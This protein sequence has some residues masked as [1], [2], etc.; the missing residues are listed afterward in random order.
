MSF[1]DK[2]R[3]GKMLH[4]KE[5]R[6]RYT[7]Y[8]PERPANMPIRDFAAAVTGGDRIIAEI[9]HRSPSHPAFT[10]PAR[11]ATLARLYQRNGAAAQSIVVDQEHFGTSLADVAEV[12]AACDLPVLTK[13]FV[14]DETQITEAWAAGADCVLL[15]VRMLEGQRLTALLAFAHDL[16]LHVLVECHDLTDIEMATAA[17]ARIVGVNNRNLATLRTDLA[18]GAGMLPHLPGGVIRVSESGLYTRDDILTMAEHGADTFLIGHALLRSDDPGRK[19]AELSA[20]E[21]EERTRV[22]VCGITNVE[23]ARMA[24]AAGADILGLILADSP[25]QVDPDQGRAIRQA[26]PR[27]RL[28]GVFVDPSLEELAGAAE[29]IDLDL[30]QLHGQ[31]SPD[32]ARAVRDR[33]G[34]PVIKALTPDQATPE[35]TAL[36][37][38]RRLHPGGPA[39]GHGTRAFQPRR[40]PARRV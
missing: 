13:D 21:P 9:K 33:L 34:L 37:E 28:C 2:I 10:Q 16:G 14:V 35:N 32:F 19:V 40:L 12:K 4:A 23:D 15:I 11:P 22:K 27:T 29:T 36:Y 24:Q 20:R 26:L 17:G 5:L 25:R 30:V 7:V 18:H 39:Q 6:E 3:P 8:P 31:E 1:L 38:G